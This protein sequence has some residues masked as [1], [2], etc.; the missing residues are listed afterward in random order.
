MATVCV[1]TGK[2]VARFKNGS[3]MK[4]VTHD[5]SASKPEFHVFEWG[6][7][8]KEARQIAV[9]SLKAVFFVKNFQGDKRHVEYKLFDRAA[10]HARKILVRF[11][12]G[13]ALVGFTVGYNPK[14]TGFFVTPADPDS[15]NQ[16]IYVVN[17]AVK[18]VHWI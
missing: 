8:T 4:G 2:V 16:R 7:E 14:K 13:E 17:S 6:D 1:K 3:L 5:F 11:R 15:N 18:S 12:D 10:V 9:E